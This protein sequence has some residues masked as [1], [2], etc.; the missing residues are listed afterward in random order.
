MCS[1]NG[2]CWMTTTGNV[3]ECNRDVSTARRANGANPQAVQMVVKAVHA[4]CPRNLKESISIK[5]CPSM[6]LN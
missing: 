1:G 5:G 2:R 3:N 4:H 6:R